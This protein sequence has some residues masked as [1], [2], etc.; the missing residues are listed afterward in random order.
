MNGW[1]RH[2]VAA[3]MAS[4]AP[5]MTEDM[6]EEERPGEAQATALTVTMA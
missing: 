3:P 4:W 2:R 6:P 1:G 5:M